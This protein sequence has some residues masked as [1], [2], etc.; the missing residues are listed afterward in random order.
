MGPAVEP[1]HHRR[2]RV[3]TWNLWWRF[4]PWEARQRA[5]VDELIALEADVVC[6]QEVWC[7]GGDDQA[8]QIGDRLGGHVARSTTDDGR[9][10]RFGNAIVSRW[11][12]LRS[13]TV[14]LGDGNGGP[15]H[16][17]AV[18]A[19]V[20]VPGSPSPWWF[21]S[22]HLDWHYARSALRQ[23]QLAVVVDHLAGLRDGADPESIPIVIGADLNAT[24]D[25][26]EVRRL[27]GRAEP[28]H[29]E[30]VF[31]DA[32]AAVGDGPGWTW[33]RS[34]PHAAD[35]QWPRRRI[36]SVLVGWPRTKPQANP[37]EAALF[38]TEPR[39]GTFGEPIVPSDHYGVVVTLDERTSLDDEPGDE[40]EDE[41]QPS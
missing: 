27:T 17:S 36:D 10:L 34:N 19:L 18:F 12:L 21:A 40:A 25:A 38:G 39:V 41:E 11:P 16:R 7:D 13:T 31:T 33:T 14:P 35:A 23:Q 2:V 3:A 29:P 8:R 15:G 22:T 37:L 1:W 20:D 6:L 28:Y 24:P 5:I 30:L 4:G 26:D 9:P 32:W